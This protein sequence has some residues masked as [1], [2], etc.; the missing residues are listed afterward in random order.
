MSTS[1]SSASDAPLPTPMGR[2]RRRCEVIV[3][4]NVF[5]AA[6]MGLMPVPIANAAVVGVV[7]LKMIN[8]LAHE[9]DQAFSQ[10]RVRAIV[11]ALLAGLGSVDLTRMSLG[12]PLLG[13]SVSIHMGVM[14]GAVTYGVGTLFVKHL[15]AGGTLENLDP[16]DAKAQFRELYQEGLTVV[17]RGL[18][19]A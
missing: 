18:K 11:M 13:V 5:W 19:R 17:R 14:A 6:F 3:I 16:Q 1:P 15:E 4:D 2:R 10:H 9:Y 7:Q 8:E 12:L